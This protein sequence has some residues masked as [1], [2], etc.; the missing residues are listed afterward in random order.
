[1]VRFS[2]TLQQ[3]ARP[4]AALGP[5]LDVHIEVYAAREV[6]MSAKF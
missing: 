4:L 1:M 3:H 5:R 2:I 6:E